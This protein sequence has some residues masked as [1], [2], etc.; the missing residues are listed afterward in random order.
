MESWLGNYKKTWKKKKFV[1]LVQASNSGSN[2]NKAK[3][4]FVFIHSMDS[5]LWT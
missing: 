4:I 5:N 1:T 3:N 2:P